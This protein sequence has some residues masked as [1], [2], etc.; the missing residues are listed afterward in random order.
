MSALAALS[1]G[2]CAAAGESVAESDLFCLGLLLLLV[3][4]C[5]CRW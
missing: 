1:R 4:L 3:L 2:A 5:G